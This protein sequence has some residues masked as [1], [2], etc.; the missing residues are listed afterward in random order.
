MRHPLAIAL[1]ILLPLPVSTRFVIRTRRWLAP[2][3]R[4][5][6]G[7]RAGPGSPIRP[8]GRLAVPGLRVPVVPVGI[9]PLYRERVIPR[10]PTWPVLAV[11]VY[12]SA[13]RRVPVGMA[14][15]GG[16]L[17]NPAV[18]PGTEMPTA[19]LPVPVPEPIVV[20]VPPIDIGVTFHHVSPRP[21]IVDH[22]HPIRVAIP[23]AVEGNGI[24]GGRF[25]VVQVAPI[26]RRH[27][28][29]AETHREPQR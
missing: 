26:H 17:F 18:L 21:R 4:Q 29:A 1:G 27:H 12:A 6:P 11:G 2:A 20:M 3:H 14:R 7:F 8:G 15:I 23:L 19:P 16:P 24:G 22:H 25:V 5:S 28:T 13:S 10:G 9:Q